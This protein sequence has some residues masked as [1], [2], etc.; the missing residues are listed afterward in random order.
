MIRVTG[1]V[2]EDE[3]DEE[4]GKATNSFVKSLECLLSPTMELR[5]DRLSCI[6]PEHT[7]VHGKFDHEQSARRTLST[8]FAGDIVRLRVVLRNCFGA[9]ILKPSTR[10]VWTVYLCQTG[11]HSPP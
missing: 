8:C 7:A 2:Q 9:P 11:D 3:S 6:T 10:T 5:S 1:L 4:D